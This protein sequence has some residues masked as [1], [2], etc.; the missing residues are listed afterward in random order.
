MPER[1]ISSAAA[2]YIGP[3]IGRETA[4]VVQAEPSQLQIPA[5]PEPSGVTT[6]PQADENGI[7]TTTLQPMHMTIEEALESVSSDYT[8]YITTN[9]TR[10][11]LIFKGPNDILT[12]LTEDLE[13]VDKPAPHIMVD[14]LA[15]ELS[16]EANQ[17]LGLDWTYTEDR[18]AFYQPAGRPIRRYGGAYDTLNTLYGTG[19]SFYQGVGELP[20]EFFIRLN[21]LVTEGE[22][23]I[24]ANPRTV[25]MSGKESL[26]NIRKTLNYFYDEGFD[27]AGRPIVRKS[28]ISADTEGRIVPTLL[29]DGTINL[30]VDVK[31]GNYTFTNLPQGSP[32][33]KL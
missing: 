31:V 18:F 15:V 25:A 1:L 29:A 32:P 10:N 4:E 11:L 21:T 3:P 14:L 30:V 12:E 33:P 16:E 27:V 9:L 13:L 6:V 26:I 24:L 17:E 22:G 7:V 28:D 19:Q 2:K 5:L 20:N 23:T 8:Q